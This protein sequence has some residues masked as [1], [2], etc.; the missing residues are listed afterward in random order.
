M[1]HGNNIG[2]DGIMSR[3]QKCWIQSVWDQFSFPVFPVPDCDVD[4]SAPTFYGRSA[5]QTESIDQVHTHRNTSRGQRRWETKE[6]KTREEPSRWLCVVFDLLIDKRQRLKGSLVAQS[7]GGGG[8]VIIYSKVV[9]SHLFY[10]TSGISQHRSST[11]QL[12]LKINNKTTT[13]KKRK[14][15]IKTPPLLPLFMYI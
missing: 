9:L 1:Q 14:W 10:Q 3:S 15:I 2:Q 6:K 8:S 4:M 12:L 11:Q 13:K 5:N 7:G